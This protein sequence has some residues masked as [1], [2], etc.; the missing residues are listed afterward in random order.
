MKLQDFLSKSYPSSSYIDEDGWDSLYLRKSPITFFI[1]GKPHPIKKV[2][3]FANIA[4]K[5]PGN[6]LFSKLVQEFVSDEWAIF[7]ECVHNVRLQQFLRRKG[8][9]E[10][11]MEG[12]PNFLFN[13][14]SQLN[15]ADIHVFD[16]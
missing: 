9:F 14:E 7:V 3:T 16:K 6:G 12:V 4:A 5:K 2:I 11:K 10:I 8:Y 15:F 1:D 13:Y